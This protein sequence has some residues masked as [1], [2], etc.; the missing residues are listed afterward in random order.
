MFRVGIVSAC[1]C[2]GLSG[3]G[4]HAVLGA[5]TLEAVRGPSLREE[6]MLLSTPNPASDAPE[7][8]SNGSEREEKASSAGSA[9]LRPPR[10]SWGGENAISWTILRKDPG[11][12]NTVWCDL[13]FDI[14]DRHM[15][16]RLRES[17][18]E[19]SPSQQH[20]SS[21]NNTP[22]EVGPNN[23]ASQNRQWY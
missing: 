15:P 20:P 8:D 6:L 21:R 11:Q 19:S 2:G 10:A 1:P 7:N 16:S 13:D 14:A 4:A 3:C 23:P 17:S 22:S 12:T 5:T 9:S 18:N